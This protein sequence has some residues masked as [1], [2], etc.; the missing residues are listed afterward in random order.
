MADYRQFCHE[1]G[2]EFGFGSHKDD[3]AAMARVRLADEERRA[4]EKGMREAIAELS[5]EDVVSAVVELSRRVEAL[6]QEEMAVEKHL[7]AVK[8]ALMLRSGGHA[9][10]RQATDR[11]RGG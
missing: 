9:L 3:C 10:L 2:N 6:A 4:W 11:L 5:D 1:C 7:R 8:E